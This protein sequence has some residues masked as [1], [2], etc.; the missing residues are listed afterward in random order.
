MKAAGRSTKSG[1]SD[2][3]E[4]VIKNFNEQLKS[5]M[6][7]MLRKRMNE[8]GVE[9]Q[10]AGTDLIDLKEAEWIEFTD[11]EHREHAPGHR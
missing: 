5:G 1:V 2:E 7:N 11:S 9:V 8:P 3:P 6:N 10:Y 4:D